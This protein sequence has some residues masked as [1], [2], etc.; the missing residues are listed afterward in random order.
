MPPQTQSAAARHASAGTTATRS[1]YLVAKDGTVIHIMHHL[2]A[3]RRQRHASRIEDARRLARLEV[4]VDALSA[5]VT[6]DSILM[7]TTS[8]QQAPAP[9]D[10]EPDYRPPA[11]H[12]EAES[13][14]LGAADDVALA[15]LSLDLWPNDEFEQITADGER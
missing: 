10:L 4:Q 6:A 15:G 5:Q 2:S 8:V 12:P 11:G 1:P 9:H 7:G 14:P 13:L 3:R